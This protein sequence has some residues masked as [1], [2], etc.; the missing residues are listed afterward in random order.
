[1][2]RPLSD[3]SLKSWPVAS[4]KIPAGRHTDRRDDDDQAVS[5]PPAQDH[6]CRHGFLLYAS[7][8][9]SGPIP[10]LRGKPGRPSRIPE[11]GVVGG[12]L[13]P[14]I[15]RPVG[16][17]VG[18]GQAAVSGLIFVKPRLRGRQGGLPADP[19]DL[20]KHTP[21]TIEPLS[22]DEAYLDLTKNLQSIPWRERVVRDPCKSGSN[23]LTLRAGSSYNKFL[24]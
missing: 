3:G 9:Q 12:E 7:R 1:L 13:S 2:Q 8:A 14:A 16:D 4:R 19:L 21:I 10:D 15:S 17:A 5:G 6:P 11:R 20:R 23:R 22:L 24:S 18:D